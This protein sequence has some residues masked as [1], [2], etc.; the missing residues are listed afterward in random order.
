MANIHHENVW[1][2]VVSIES[3]NLNLSY[4][5]QIEFLHT[6][7]QIFS[8]YIQSSQVSKLRTNQIQI[9]ECDPMLVQIW[10]LSLIARELTDGAFDPWAVTGGFDPSGYVKGWAADQIC[11]QLQSAG[12]KHIQVNA[13]GD[14]SLRG[15]SSNQKPWQI[16]VAH[17]QLPDEI[18]KVF[19]IT[20]GAI[21]TSGTAERGNHIIDPQSK[22]I[23][24]GARSATVVGPDGGLA[25]ALATA[26][27]VTGRDGAKW[28]T[29]SELEKYSCWV[30]DRHKDTT[31]EIIK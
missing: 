12:V 22:T 11:N 19:Q 3:E 30:V 4:Q 9:Q 1:G 29:K 13:G 26:L 8:T 6:I 21:A 15:G 25:D 10:Q 17:P 23:A 7:D 16:G 20:D 14:I 31:W 28:F 24:V 5:P 2:T 27:I 18:S